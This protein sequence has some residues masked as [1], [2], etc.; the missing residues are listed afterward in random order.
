MTAIGALS[1]EKNGLVAQMEERTCRFKSGPNHQRLACRSV[2]MIYTVKELLGGVVHH[3]PK[4]NY[5]YLA[6]MECKKTDA[7]YARAQG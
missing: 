1:G 4:T 6:R 3:A 5:Y 2:E 7:T